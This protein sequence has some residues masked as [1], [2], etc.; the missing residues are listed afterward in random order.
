MPTDPPRFDPDHAADVLLDQYLAEGWRK[1]VAD[2]A[3]ERR[4]VRRGLAAVLAYLAACAT[5]GTSFELHAFQRETTPAE[6]TDV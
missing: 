6:S 2:P 4:D 3:R 1:D 5:P